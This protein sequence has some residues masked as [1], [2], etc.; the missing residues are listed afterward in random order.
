MA[1]AVLSRRSCSGQADESGFPCHGFSDFQS[2]SV[3]QAH[4]PWNVLRHGTVHM[5]ESEMKYIKRRGQSEMNTFGSLPSPEIRPLGPEVLRCPTC[6][7]ADLASRVRG[8][9]QL[10][11]CQASVRPESY[12][13]PRDPG[14]KVVV[15]TDVVS[16]KRTV[17]S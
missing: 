12:Q 2:T 16:R 10:G 15:S 11:A 14:G 17:A 4:W 3:F 7:H 5:T 9:L 13:R 8:D 6:P 1:E